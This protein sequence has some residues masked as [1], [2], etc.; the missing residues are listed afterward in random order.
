[1]FLPLVQLFLR[2]QNAINYMREE[3]KWQN[4]LMACM[5]FISIENNFRTLV[6]WVQREILCANIYDRHVTGTVHSPHQEC[7]II[8]M[9]NF[10]NLLKLILI[11]NN[12]HF[13]WVEHVLPLSLSLVVHWIKVALSTWSRPKSKCKSINNGRTSC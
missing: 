12:T 3:I 10:Q 8:E 4:N 11:L 13:N 9:I 6:Q 2:K 1:M 5:P 7:L